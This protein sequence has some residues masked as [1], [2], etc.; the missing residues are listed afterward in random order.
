MQI[1]KSVVIPGD[2]TIPNQQNFIVF[3]TGWVSR[4]GDTITPAILSIEWPSTSCFAVRPDCMYRVIDLIDQLLVD[5]YV[6][7]K[8]N[9]AD[10]YGC[11]D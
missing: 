4:M 11:H 1:K 2:W 7:A 10:Q 6:N 8:L 5:Q 9:F 3:V